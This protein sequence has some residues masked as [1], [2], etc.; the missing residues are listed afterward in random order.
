MKLEIWADSFHEGDWCCQQ[1]AQA[2]VN[3]FGFDKP[4]VSYNMGFQPVYSFRKGDVSFSLTVYG[5]YKSWDDIPQKISEILS[6]GKP[7]FILYDLEKDAV[8]FAV[9]ETAATAT[10][11]QCMQRL[12]R[13]YGS[14]R[15]HIPYWYLV[16]E[17]GLHHDGGTRR[18]SIWPVVAATKL[19]IQKKAPSVVVH[20]SDQ[21]NLE[22]YS[23]G[24]GL[25]LLFSSLSRMTYNYAKGSNPLKDMEDLL[26][27]QYR[28]MMLFLL[29]QWS[30]ILNFLPSEAKVRSP[31][32]AEIIAKYA[33]GNNI[34]ED[35]SLDDF[36]HW[37]KTDAVPVAVMTGMT[38][39]DLLKPDVLLKHVEADVGRKLA[40]TLS[41]NAGSGK[42]PTTARLTGY[43][44]EQERKFRT[45]G[46]KDLSFSL[47]IDDFPYT[48]QKRQR[49][50]VTTAKNIVYL[51]DRWSDF[52]ASLI[53]AYPRLK[54]LK[55]RF[56]D[57][58]PVFLYVSNSVKC[59]RIFGD[60][61]TGQI[62]G[63]S[64]IFGKFDKAAR[65]VIAYYPHQVMSQAFTGKGK[66]RTNK[67]ITL[68]GEV[69]DL[70]IFHGGA[71]ACL[72]KGELY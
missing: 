64:T 28:E 8:I 41:S 52:Y 61:F 3:S 48:N 70:A 43:I 33:M 47:N 24:K 1:I 55:N 6:W 60:P 51:Y 23:S 21:D 62:T 46:L 2:L 71:A 17:Y 59:G 65:L 69:S 45:M 26:T 57:D 29:D 13:Q 40:Y 9:E 34:P 68:L 67:G 56:D 38:A 44:R 11:N 36:L 54:R 15:F 10:G 49:H 58:M 14:A 53:K 22:D 50:H 20:Y 31:K 66:L 39:R 16:S 12:E 42:P 5:S 4:S 72:S 25:N 63:Y 37:P 32:T 18:D 7:D 27:K 30:N 19:T 35:E